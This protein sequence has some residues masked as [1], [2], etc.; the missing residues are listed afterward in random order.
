MAVFNGSRY[1][2]GYVVTQYSPTRGVVTTTVRRRFPATIPPRSNAFYWDSSLRW[3]QVAQEHL[4]DYTRY[5]KILDANPLLLDPL[6]AVPGVRIEVP[7]G[8]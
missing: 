7:D 6:G 4:S 8:S 1:A 5:W 3:D 2:D